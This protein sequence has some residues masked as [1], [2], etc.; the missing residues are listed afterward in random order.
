M[1]GAVIKSRESFGRTKN[2][3]P[4]LEQ[5]GPG[6]AE[7]LVSQLRTDIRAVEMRALLDDECVLE[8]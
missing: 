8:R 2:L 3:K 1:S 6:T 5:A 7:D 4:G